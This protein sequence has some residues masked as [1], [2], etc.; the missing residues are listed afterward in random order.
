MHSFNG[1]NAALMLGKLIMFASGV[2]R[3]HP[4]C[5]LIGNARWTEMNTDRWKPYRCWVGLARLY[6]RNG[7]GLARLCSPSGACLDGQAA[8]HAQSMRLQNL[9]RA[10]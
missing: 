4:T 2:L 6:T 5:K 7:A 1:G 9:S 10:G 3:A 8:K